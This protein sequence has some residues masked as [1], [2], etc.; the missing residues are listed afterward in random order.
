MKGRRMN[1]IP[2]CFGEKHRDYMRRCLGASVCVAEGAVRSGKT[3]DHVFVFA[4]LLE[5]A[6]DRLHLATGPTLANARLNIGSCNGFG[7][8]ALFRGRCRWGKF[9]DNE[10]LRVRTATGEKII[11]FAGGGKADSFRKIRGNSYGMWIATEINL[12]HDSMI[13]EAFNRQLAAKRRRVFWDLNPEGPGAAIYTD[14]LDRYAAMQAKGE[15][16]GGYCYGHFTIRDNAALPPGRIGEIEAQYDR[17]SVWYRRDILGERCAAEGLVYPMFDPAR[18]VAVRRPGPRAEW[19]LSV[20]YGTMNPC[21]MGLWAVERGRA[22]R[23][24]EWYHDGRRTRRSMTDEEYYTALERLAGRRPVRYV[25]VDPS[26][27]SFIEC[28][29]RHGRFRV[30]GAQNAVIPGIRTV[31][32]MLEAGRLVIDPSCA[33]CIREIR[34]YRWE[35]GGEDR[36]VKENDHAM[37]DMRYFCYTVLRRESWSREEEKEDV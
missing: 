17:A 33:D 15:F 18:H 23:A 14:Y 26:A 21:S 29:R 37:D 32:S 34:S 6:P 2:F 8:E 35:D 7:L 11:I 1:N 13:R 20:D 10:C 24:A 28:I 25:I 9:Q 30:R 4:K 22:L 31:G 27:A 12:H 19:Y 16:P 3:V 5:D 36:V